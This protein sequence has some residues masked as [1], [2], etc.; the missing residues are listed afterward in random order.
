MYGSTG[1][2]DDDGLGY[3]NGNGKWYS[4]CLERVHLG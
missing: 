2:D 3:D 4:F 1:G